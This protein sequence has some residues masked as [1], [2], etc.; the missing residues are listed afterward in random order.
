MKL[1]ESF[2][3]KYNDEPDCWTA[4]AYD[5]AGIA[6]E[7]IKAVGPDRKAIR[8][9]LA[10]M[11]TA[12]DSYAGVTGLTFFD[13]N[14]DC[15]KPAYVSIVKDGK[16]SLPLNRCWTGQVD[17]RQGHILPSPRVFVAVYSF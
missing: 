6:I 8:D 11:T 1:L 12:E 9:Y 13:Q 16:L 3:K 17:S 2:K 7:A 10:G 15:Q 4:L 5:A 14:G